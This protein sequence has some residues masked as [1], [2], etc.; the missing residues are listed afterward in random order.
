MNQRISLFTWRDGADQF[1]SMTLFLRRH[2]LLRA[3][4]LIMASI[5][6]SAWLV[7]VSTLLTHDHSTAAARYLSVVCTVFIAM[8]AWVWLTR[9][10]TRWQSE[11]TALGGTALIACWSV[12]QPAPAMAALTCAAL[13][14]I[15]AYLAVFHSLRSLV[16]HAAV[17]LAASIWAVWRLNAASDAAA[18]VAAFWLIWF[19]NVS[20]PVAAAGLSR[21]VGR[22][23]NSADDDD[24]T[25]LLNRRGFTF[26]VERVLYETAKVRQPTHPPSQLVVLMID[27]DNFKRIND[28]FGHA[29]G[30]RVIVNVAK[31]LRRHAPLPAIL[32]RAGGEEF[33]IAVITQTDMQAVAHRMRE[34]IADLPDGITAS[35]G[36]ASTAA[37]D[38]YVDAAAAS[39]AELITDADAAMY[40]VKANGGNDV[41]V[42][43]A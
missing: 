38:M 31:L 15:G 43:S 39:I 19:L 12:G 29:A 10:P 6:A 34:A 37:P 8:T 16:V 18:A 40:E 21:V 42:A 24:L 36:I 30:D 28:S 9:W 7:P 27:I 33:L 41:R 20:I 26:E 4:R 17:T 22:Y 1:E 35:I 3:T 13:S 23:A 2:R 32:C 25:G 5:A 14:V 11:A